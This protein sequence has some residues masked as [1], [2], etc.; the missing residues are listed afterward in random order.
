MTVFVTSDPHYWHQNVIKYCNRPY[1]TVEEMNE[2]LIANH[3]S[4]V[5][6]N[7][8]V[9]FLGDMFFCDNE[10]ARAILR[11]LKGRKHLVLG[12]HDTKIA[13][14]PQDW[15]DLF[16][17]IS[18]YV[19]RSLNGKQFVMSH[20][21]MLSWNRSHRG[22]I[23]LHGHCHG[24]MAYPASMEDLAIMDVGVDCNNYTPI[25]IADILAKG[26]KFGV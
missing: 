22:S 8:E 20:Y 7:D 3:N 4:V 19:E 25:A 1:A 15:L 21:P 14:H 16:E 2:G 9:Y 5:H 10:K 26:G 13:K 24:T 12:N 6:S 11:R 23:M 18:S 17:S